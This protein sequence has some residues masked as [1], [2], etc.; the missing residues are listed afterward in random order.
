MQQKLFSTKTYTAF[1]QALIDSGCRLCPLAQERHNIVVDRGNPEAKV[2]MIGEAP[3]ENEDLQGKAFVG[4]AGKLL[5]G[6]LLELGFET[7]RDSL[8]I[9]IAKCRPPGN[10]R[11]TP[12]EAAAC[13]PYL[14]KQLAF[15]NQRIILLLGA[16]ALQHILG[17]SFRT[18]AVSKRKKSPAPMKDLVGNFFDSPGFPGVRLMV[19]YHPA[20]ILRDPRKKSVMMEHLR[21]FVEAWKEIS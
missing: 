20:Y 21:K 6:M 10:R 7:N 14:E 1:K 8:I 9:N 12:A 2:V 19:I 18:T 16:T 5:D 13:R 4:R 11:P 3:G 15:V 17:P